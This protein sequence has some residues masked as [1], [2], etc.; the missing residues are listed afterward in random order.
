MLD[1]TDS[2]NLHEQKDLLRFIT[3]GS[4]DD[5]KS[6][7]I[8]RLLYECQLIHDDQM[9][10][11]ASDSKRFG[12]TDE[13]FDFALLVDGLASEREQGITIDVAYRFFNT[14]KRKFI[15][16]D[17]PGHEQYTRN[18]AT[19]ASTAHAA[20]VLVDARKGLLTQTCRH[21]YIVSMLGVKHVILAINKMDLVAYDETIYDQI[22]QAYITFSDALGFTKIEVIPISALKGDQIQTNSTNMPWYEG[23]TLVDYLEQIPVTTQS[24]TEDPFRM[25]VQWV[26]RPHGDFRGFSGR[27]ASGCLKP[28]DRVKTLPGLQ[29]TSIERI[30]TYDGDLDVAVTGQSITCVLK[31]EIDLSRGSVLVSHD[32]PCETSEQFEV[33]LLWMHEKPMVSGR[34]Y[35]LKQ[36]PTSALCTLGKLK[37]QI[38]VNTM[39]HL[40]AKELHLNETGRCDMML[41]QS[42]PFE[43]YTKNKALGGFILI[44]RM[45]N[46]TVAAGFIE[47]ALRRATNIHEQHLTINQSMRA[48]IKAQK[49]M[50][51]WFTGLSGSGKSTIA[52]LVEQRLNHLGK[53][54]MLLDGDNIRRG[55]NCDL[56]FTD[57]GRAENIRRIAEVSK[58]MTEA[59]L[60]TLVSFISPFESEREMAKNLIGDSQFL[61]VFVDASLALAET[62]D[63][64]GLYKKAR[65]GEI[66]N[67]TGIGSPYERPTN[68]DLQLDVAN[69]SAEAAAEQVLDLLKLKK[70]F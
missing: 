25:P 47:F 45:T 6:T 29:E 60:I 21:S 55:L 51:I 46:A 15:V 50:V 65:A 1:F 24:E 10:K 67:F 61:E 26:N 31:D 19:G 8:G 49:P 52:N 68:P 11:L 30:V 22:K 20:I 9:D 39:E 28:G 3:C 17:T 23:P 16:A 64:K 44:D 7:L 14:D 12:T 66:K 41:D 62:R 4:V 33:Q 63:V 18:M 54:S 13:L 40:A 2:L 35:L 58:L 59:G 36:G 43:P 53:H 37:Y 48:D 56:D 70:A 42:I 5:G 32:A 38:D 69:L 57:T 34:Q 27:I